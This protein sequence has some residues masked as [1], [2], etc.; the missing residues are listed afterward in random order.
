VRVGDAQNSELQRHTCR[1]A[2]AWL[3]NHALYPH[4]SQLWNLHG[5]NALRQNEIHTAE[6]LVTE[7]SVFEVEVAI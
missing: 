6:R 2:E 7:P 4:F 3:A 5:I 1:R